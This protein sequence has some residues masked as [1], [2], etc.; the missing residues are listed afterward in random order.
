MYS[1]SISEL[2]LDRNIAELRFQFFQRFVHL[3]L[4][5]AKTA[6][7]IV[8]PNVRLAATAHDCFTVANLPDKWSCPEIAAR[9]MDVNALAVEIECHFDTPF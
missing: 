7:V 3:S 1:E 5:L 9:A 4:S 2:D 8:Q 6:Q